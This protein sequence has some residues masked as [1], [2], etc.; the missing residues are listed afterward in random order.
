[1]RNLLSSSKRSNLF[2]NE[3]FLKSDLVLG[4]S[5]CCKNRLEIYFDNKYLEEKGDFK[6]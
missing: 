6:G 4:F 5:W 2:G 1:M 3:G